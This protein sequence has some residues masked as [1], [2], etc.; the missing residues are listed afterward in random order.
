M[1][2]TIR[3]IYLAALTVFP[4]HTGHTHIIIIMSANITQY[5]QTHVIRGLVKWFVVFQTDVTSCYMCRGTSLVC[6]VSC[7]ITQVTKPLSYTKRQFDVEE[8]DVDK[9]AL[10]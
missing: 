2:H 1:R 8:D 4:T 6:H 7:F 3:S 10:K 5:H 9:L